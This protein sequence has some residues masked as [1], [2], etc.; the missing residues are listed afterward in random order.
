M[1]PAETYDRIAQQ[2]AAKLAARQLQSLTEYAVAA[3]LTSHEM[4][5]NF[6]GTMIAAD[7]QGE[8]RGWKLALILLGGTIPDLGGV[9]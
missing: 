8:A 2:G 9:A 7:A 5:L 6:P 4:A 3:R 1:I